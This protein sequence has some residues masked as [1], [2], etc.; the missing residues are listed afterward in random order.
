M[1]T[2][3][4]GELG[5]TSDNGPTKDEKRRDETTNKDDDETQ[6]GTTRDEE[7]TTIEPHK[8]TYIHWERSQSNRE[9]GDDQQG[10]RR[11]A[12]RDDEG[13]GTHND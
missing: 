11:D 12:R 7:L 2:Q 13:R 1:H 4:D 9:L 10:R 6:D 3:R 8:C 5:A